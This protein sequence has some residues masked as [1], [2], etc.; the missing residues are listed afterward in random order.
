TTRRRLNR[1]GDRTAN[2]ALWRIVMVRMV[3]DPRTRSYVERRTREGRSKREIIRSLKR[4]VARE[5]YR[6]LPIPSPLDDR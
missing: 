2:Q 6:C 5:L 1:G 3:H 4:Y